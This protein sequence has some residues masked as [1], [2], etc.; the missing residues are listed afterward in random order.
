MYIMKK[1]KRKMANNVEEDLNTKKR[2]CQN[3][4][5]D[6]STS[7]VENRYSTRSKTSKKIATS[8]SVQVDSSQSNKRKERTDNVNDSSKNKEK[9][10]VDKYN[11]LSK[12]RRRNQNE[13]VIMRKE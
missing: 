10:S 11:N 3:L 5:K 12:R 4:Q 6:I 1:K 13:T 7:N 2:K 9:N 8:E